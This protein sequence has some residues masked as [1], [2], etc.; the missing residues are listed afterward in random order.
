MLFLDKIR[1]TLKWRKMLNDE[2][3]ILALILYIV[4]I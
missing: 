3:Q 4:H 1:V 2:I